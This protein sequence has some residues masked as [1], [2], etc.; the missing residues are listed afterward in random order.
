MTT[1]QCPYCEARHVDDWES[2]EAD[3]PGT[4]RCPDCGREFAFVLK[5]CDQCGADSVM[6]WKQMPSAEALTALFCQSCGESY[7]DRG[8]EGDSPAPGRV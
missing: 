4:M 6:V 5:E 7:H 2:I 1:L 8:E 3:T